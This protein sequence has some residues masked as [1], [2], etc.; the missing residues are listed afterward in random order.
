MRR[1][2]TKIPLALPASRTRKPSG[3]GSMIAWRREHRLSLRTRSQE[4]SRPMTTS[5]S[6]NSTSWGVPSGWETSSFM[7]GVDAI[8]PVPGF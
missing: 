7:D 8:G 5:W 3:V 2:F 1:P 4:G 6:G